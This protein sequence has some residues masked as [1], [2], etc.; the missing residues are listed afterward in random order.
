MSKDL[1]VDMK[2]GILVLLSMGSYTSDDTWSCVNNDCF[3]LL[4]FANRK[5][6]SEKKSAFGDS[7]PPVLKW[8]LYIY[9]V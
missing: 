9:N 1:L 6:Q 2:I 5:F 3:D 8:L 4:A 7:N